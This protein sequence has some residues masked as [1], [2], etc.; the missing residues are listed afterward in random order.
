MT[1]DMHSTGDPDA[2]CSDCGTPGDLVRARRLLHAADLENSASMLGRE[3]T[4]HRPHVPLGWRVLDFDPDA[5]EGLPPDV[6]PS[7]AG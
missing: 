2:V 1:P 4:F 5:L 7:P 3:A 6:P